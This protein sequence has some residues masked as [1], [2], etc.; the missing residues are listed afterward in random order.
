MQVCLFC[1]V[2]I[3]NQSTRLCFY[4]SA[5]VASYIHVHVQVIQQL[6][7]RAGTECVFTMRISVHNIG[8]VLR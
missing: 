6:Y 4:Q 5:A 8:R 3:S 2:V 1:G 7:S